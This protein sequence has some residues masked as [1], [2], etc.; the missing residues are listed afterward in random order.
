MKKRCALV[1]TGM[2]RC[3]EQAYPAMKENFLD[4]LECD[5]F[6]DIWSEKGY[7]SGKGYLPEKNGFVDTTPNEKGFFD[8]GELVDANKIMEIYKPKILHIQDFS[9]IE[10]FFE[11]EK[12]Y[13][14]NAYTRPKNTLAQ[15]YK[16]Y[17]GSN[18]AHEYNSM[19]FQQT[20]TYDIMVRARPDIVL[21]H[22]I[23]IDLLTSGHFLTLPSRNKN[24]RGTGDSIQIGNFNQMVS[25]NRSMWTRRKTIYDELEI[26][27][28]HLFVEHILKSII[29]RDSILQWIELHGIGAHVAHS[30]TGLYAEPD[31]K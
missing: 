31:A 11:H 10:S 5:V 14:K 26:S 6:I 3:W 16:M 30:P 7:Y 25:F 12:E 21:E 1:L 20:G 19:F 24:N 28:P 27:C 8:S 18:M 29:N 13:F 17:T 2:S 4:R 9:Q 15:S 22:L 23:P